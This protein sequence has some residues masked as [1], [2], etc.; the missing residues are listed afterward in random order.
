M[1]DGGSLCFV[2]KPL[3]VTGVGVRIRSLLD[4]MT[5]EF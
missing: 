5:F 4:D 1:N 3:T 2:T